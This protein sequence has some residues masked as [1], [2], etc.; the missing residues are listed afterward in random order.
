MTGFGR[1]ETELAGRRTLVEITSL[2]HRNLEVSVLLPERY[3]A[4]E[5]EIRRRVSDQ[6]SRG[7]LRL[8]V[9]NAED[10]GSGANPWR[11]QPQVLEA[12]LEAFEKIR[13][14][15]G[16]QGSIGA[17]DLLVA[18]GVVAPAGGGDAYADEAECE[19][20]VGL[21][22]AGLAALLESR[23]R[24][25]VDLD[26][27]LRA[28]TGNLAELVD[29]VETHLPVVRDQIRERWQKRLEEQLGNLRVP[30]ERVMA[31]M[32]ML[33]DRNECSEELVRLRAHLGAFRQLLDDG[34]AVGRKL[35]FLAQEM[36]RE[37]NTL[38]SKAVDPGCLE[39]VIPIKDEVARVR[40]QVENV[41]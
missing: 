8:A 9:R 4:A 31:E 30:E 10:A 19:A 38:G 39:W 1:A 2:N 3:A 12:Y 23:R 17:R 35:A 34:G 13:T 15:L 40:E 33:L 37:A 11:F 14:R 36:G 7:K 26:L 21:V 5:V 28:R 29:R 6:L 27:D 20:L 24:E 16:D 32:V 18:P 22:E 41:E 25:G